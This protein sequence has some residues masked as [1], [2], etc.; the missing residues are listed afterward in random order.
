MLRE[1]CVTQMFLVSRERSSPPSQL[2]QATCR[3]YCP[4]YISRFIS[5]LSLLPYS[6]LSSFLRDP[7]P[8]VVQA[9]GTAR[10][11]CH[12]DGVPAPSITWEKNHV[13]LHGPA[14]SISA[15]RWDSVRIT[16]K[17]LTC[18]LLVVNK[19]QCAVYWVY[20]VCLLLPFYFFYVIFCVVW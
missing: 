10:F 6:G 14:E 18:T 16:S 9:G 15:P 7:E 11:E 17:Q 12:I 2:S 19:R 8:Q 5:F 4:D 3:V 20:Y 13:P 1:A